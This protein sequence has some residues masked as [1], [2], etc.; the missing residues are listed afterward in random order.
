MTSR[1]QSASTSAQQHKRL[2]LLVES[3]LELPS[4]EQRHAF[5]EKECGGDAA[6][7]QQSKE[8]LDV[9]GTHQGRIDS[10]GDRR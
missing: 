6:L 3:A 8:L 4:G 10:T 1:E 9:E 7:Y 5:L 2:K